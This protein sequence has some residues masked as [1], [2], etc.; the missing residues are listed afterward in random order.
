MK[1]FVVIH[2]LAADKDRNPFL[3][4]D[5]EVLAIVAPCET[6]VEA[7]C[8]ADDYAATLGRKVRAGRY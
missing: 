7:T 6:R 2:N 4:W 1:R 8:L 3:V 5:R